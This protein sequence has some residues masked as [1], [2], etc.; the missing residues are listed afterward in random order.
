MHEARCRTIQPNPRNLHTV[1]WVAPISG[2]HVFYLDKITGRS[3]RI[4]TSGPCVP[5]T[6]LYQAELHSDRCAPSETARSAH[7]TVRPMCRKARNGL[8]VAVAG[9][10]D[11]RMTRRWRSAA[12]RLKASGRAAS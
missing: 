5:N 9:R 4:R 7:I 12:V 1:R 11:T 3:E 2:K 8:W 6:V 10:D